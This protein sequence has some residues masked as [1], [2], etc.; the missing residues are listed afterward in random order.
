MRNLA[1]D[2]LDLTDNHAAVRHLLRCILFAQ[3]DSSFDVSAR[4]MM[5]Q[6]VSGSNLQ[7]YAPSV[8]NVHFHDNG[9]FPPFP[10]VFRT[11]RQF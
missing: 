2:I 4:S 1:N 6:A 9:H 11:F 7:E 3:R 8:K 5:P 10:G